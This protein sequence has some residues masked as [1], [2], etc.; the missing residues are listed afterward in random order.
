[1]R[2]KTP[3]LDRAAFFM[4][5]GAKLVTVEGTYPENMFVL[6]VPKPISWYEKMGGWV[7]YD[8]FCEKRRVI[9]RKSRKLAG[10]P[11]HFTGEVKKGFTFAD[12]AIVKRG[13]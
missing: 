5:F 8:E 1:M 6:D 10:L 4:V 11:A 9:K 12:I 7:P 3:V 2:I 13:K